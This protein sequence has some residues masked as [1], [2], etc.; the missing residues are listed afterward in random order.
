MQRYLIRRLIQMVPVFIGITF[1]T[2]LMISLAPGDPVM[3]LYP[4]E[5]LDRVDLDLLRD[6]LGLNDPLPVQYAQM[7]GRFLTGDLDSFQERRP[8][9]DLIFDRLFPTLMFATLATFLALL[10]GLPVAIISALRPYSWF[11]NVS[12]V[13]VLTGLSLPQFWFA[14]LLIL[15]FSERLRLLPSSG[16]R[17]IDAT[18]YNPVEMLPY[19]IMPTLVLSLGLLPSIMRY[20][21][22][23]MI[24]VLSQDYVRTAH[25]KGLSNRRVLLQHALRNAILPVVTLIGAIFP[26]LLGGA[27]VVETIFGIPGI[28]RLAVRSA[29]VRDLPVI[30][31][32]NIFAAVLILLS[33]LLTDI[34]YTYLD[35]RIRLG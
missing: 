4:P 30:L 23:S 29:Q 2:F 1:I 7:M 31:S 26:L 3:S 11:D 14:L 9:M 10:I 33:N 24:E 5:V 25:S 28:G 13:S 22:S 27:A 17:P 18:S 32:L 20:S 19:L 15:F 34:F 12:T 6:Q 16:I 21:R 8:A 35:P